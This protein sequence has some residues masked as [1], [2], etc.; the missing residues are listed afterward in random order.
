MHNFTLIKVDEEWVTK[1]VKT[2]TEFLPKFLITRKS[3]CSKL[4]CQ[5]VLCDN[6]VDIL[7]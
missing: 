3:L 7:A 4:W 5:S 6:L 1:A 2:K